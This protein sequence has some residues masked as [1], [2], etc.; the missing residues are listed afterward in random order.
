[1]SL[2]VA[3]PAGLSRSARFATFLREAVAIKTKRVF[4]VQKY[5]HVVWF[6]DFPQ[7]LPEVRSP[8]FSES[9]P[10]GDSA[11]LKVARV[12]EPARPAVPAEC[13]PW[14]RDV[15]L[16]TP[17][18]TPALNPTYEDRDRRG[19][20]IEIPVTPEVIGLWERYVSTA[21]VDAHRK[22][23]ISAR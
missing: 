2:D 19:E 1:M 10:E 17:G 8:L 4:E 9:W 14:L 13:A 3:D 16:D 5:P 11:W 20:P 18:T 12:Q 15:D 21:C 23:T 6:T 7:D 22:L